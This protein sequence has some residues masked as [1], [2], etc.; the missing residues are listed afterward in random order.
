MDPPLREKGSDI[1]DDEAIRSTTV[2]KRTR[3]LETKPALA[4]GPPHYGTAVR[5]NL[6][7]FDLRAV[8][9]ADANRLLTAAT[10]AAQFVGLDIA[11]TLSNNAQLTGTVAKV[12]S[13]TQ[14][15]HLRDGK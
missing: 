5:G 6:F 15:L 13:T 2:P 14:I 7:A 4:R 8:T 11:V 12:D 10:M 9:C 3:V 1:A